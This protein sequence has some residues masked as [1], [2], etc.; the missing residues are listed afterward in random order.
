[1]YRWANARD[2]AGLFKRRLAMEI[3]RQPLKIL[4]E[5][6]ETLE[7]KTI[8]TTPVNMRLAKDPAGTVCL[9]SLVY[10]ADKLDGCQTLIH[11][12]VETLVYADE[13]HL[14]KP[15]HEVVKWNCWVTR[16]QNILIR[17]NRT[18]TKLSV[19][20]P[21]TDTW[22]NYDLDVN[23]PLLVYDRERN[24]S[25]L[26]LGYRAKNV[27]LLETTDGLIDTMLRLVAEF[28]REYDAHSNSSNVITAVPNGRGMRR[29]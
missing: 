18:Q 3:A 21:R 19:F 10:T 13:T 12:I 23:Y 29:A 2:A 4:R 25:V 15:V 17:M 24:V 20:A 22:E 8:K 7:A 26:G 28:K 27:N 9:Q 6:L 11:E 16:L 1:M 5:R 14:F